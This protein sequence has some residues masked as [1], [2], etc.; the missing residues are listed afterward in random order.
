MLKISLIIPCYNHGLYI[1]DAIDSVELHPDKDLYEIIIINDGSTDE[2][3]I[4]LLQELKNKGYNV[5]F[6]KNQGLGKTRNNGIKIAKGKYILPLDADN[7]ISIEYI[8]KSIEILDNNPEYCV[9]YGDAEYF[10]EKEGVWKVGEFD[11]DKMIKSNYI[12]ACAVYRKSEWIKYGAYK[13]DM[14]YQGLEDWDFW[15]TLIENGGKFYYIPEILFYYRVLNNSMIASIMKDAMKQKILNSY[16]FYKHINLYADILDP[17]SAHRDIIKLDNDIATLNKYIDQS[18]EEYETKIN[19]L[20][21]S[22]SYRLGNLFL[23]P[24]SF[25]KSLFN[26]II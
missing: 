26:K 24:F 21:K 4:N 7:K 6:Q 13:E 16:V 19:N 10:G 5:I 15:L 3:T 12:D 2:Y 18:K 8:N 14:P 22:T 17:I 20:K 1:M 9:V 25:F 23:K 11:K